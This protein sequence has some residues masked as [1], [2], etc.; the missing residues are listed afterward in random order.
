MELHEIPDVKR[1]EAGD[2][3]ER[4]DRALEIYNVA[5][6]KASVH[7]PVGK[8]GIQP[9]LVPFELVVSCMHEI[10]RG[11]RRIENADAMDVA[12]RKEIS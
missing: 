3:A 4:F 8:W 10:L 5:C 9:S 6:G 1:G 11:K 7:A 12:A 2:W